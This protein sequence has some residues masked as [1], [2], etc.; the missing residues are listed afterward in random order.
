MTLLC[1]YSR[2]RLFI[3]ENVALAILLCLKHPFM[4]LLSRLSQLLVMLLSRERRQR[5]TDYISATE[6][7][8][9]EE[10]DLLCMTVSGY[11]DCK[12]PSFIRFVAADFMKLILIILWELIYSTES[13]LHAKLLLCKSCSCAHAIWFLH[14]H[15]MN[16]SKCIEWGIR[17]PVAY[18]ID[19]YHHSGDCC[20]KETTNYS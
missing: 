15:G 7:P 11:Q 14:S 12:L 19:L 4:T 10:A 1:L 3:S 16:C 9:E 17:V 13:W 18:W 6:T 8:G 5:A 2:A 20:Q